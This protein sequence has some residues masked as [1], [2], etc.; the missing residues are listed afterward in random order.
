MELA[1]RGLGVAV[2]ALVAG[3]NAVFELDPTVVIDSGAD[4]DRDGVFDATDNCRTV[5]NA[6]QTNSDD[7]AFGDACDTCPTT[8]SA[9]AHDE[10]GDGVGDACDVCPGIRD[11]QEDADKD[12]VGD[13]CDPDL[14]GDKASPVPRMHKRVLFDGFETISAD[15]QPSGVAWNVE[16]DAAVPVS[17]MPKLD[18]GLT[19]MAVTT[20]GDWIVTIEY[21]STSIWNTQDQVAVGADVAGT[22]F[23]CEGSCPADVCKHFLGYGGATASFDGFTPRARSH[24]HGGVA[25]ATQL[26]CGYEGSNGGITASA[27]QTQPAT[28]FSIAGSPN[29]RI[30]Y[31]EVIQ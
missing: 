19:N 9:S 13:L 23:R 31:I 26:G 11:F 4:F 15:W 17:V 25:T 18:H 8:P 12:G 29:V 1:M 30:T 24:V 7:D 21:R 16:A 28:K 5:P 22:Y 27:P 2:I 20:T 10:D 6:D 14:I 3:C